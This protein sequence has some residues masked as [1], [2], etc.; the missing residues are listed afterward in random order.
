MNPLLATAKERFRASDTRISNHRKMVESPSFEQS[1]DAALIQY[2]A[3]LSQ[4][5]RDAN[6]ALAAGFRLN[7]AFELMHTLKN[8]SEAPIVPL[9]ERAPDNLNHQV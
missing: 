1:S 3:I 7:G 8:I 6:T 4:G 5:V 2:M 9:A